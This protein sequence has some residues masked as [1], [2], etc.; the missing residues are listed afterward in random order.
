MDDN[1]YD[2][3]DYRDI[4]PEFGTL[5]DFERL[6]AE[7]RK[8]EI[9]VMLDLVV[10]H[11]SDEHPWFQQSRKAVDNPFRNFYI[12]RKPAADGGPPN[13]LKSSFGGPAWTLDAE[14]G[15]YYLH[16]FSRRQPD[17][18]WENPA[19]RREIYAM[20]NWWLDRGIA[21]FRMDVIDYIGKQ[22]DQELIK[23]GPYLHD[24]LQE[25]NAETFGARDILTVGETWSATPGLRTALL[26]TRPQANYR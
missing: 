26:R 6:V 4:A 18:N 13:G 8:R 12:W 17:L 10:N 7:A 21:G 20:M 1:G 24:Y 9:G 22:P 15:E 16:M 3:S 23:D 25:M 5:A 14:T 2:I 19:V 11:T